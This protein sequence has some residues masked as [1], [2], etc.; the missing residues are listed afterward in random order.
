MPTAFAIFPVEL[1][2]PVHFFAQ[3]YYSHIVHWHHQPRGGHF[4]ALEEPLLLAQ[5]IWSFRGALDASAGV[6][7]RKNFSE[8]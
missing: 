2:V 3:Q 8:L 7:S 1:F 5:D 4:A 6:V